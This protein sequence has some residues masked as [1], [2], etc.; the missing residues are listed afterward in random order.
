MNR[1][2]KFDYELVFSKILP[3]ENPVF[4]LNTIQAV[5]L[6]ENLLFLHPCNG[7]EDPVS[8]FLSQDMARIKLYLIEPPV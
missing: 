5:N 1:I 3:Q 4:K 7:R 6:R 8:G 2:R